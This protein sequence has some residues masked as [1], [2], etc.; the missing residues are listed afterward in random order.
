[1]VTFVEITLL[2]GGRA[3]DGN[4][5]SYDR[6]STGNE[7]GLYDSRSNSDDKSRDGTGRIGIYSATL[8]QNVDGTRE[9]Y[10][11]IG[12]GSMSPSE[13][14]IGVLER[15]Y[16]NLRFRATFNGRAIDSIFPP[17]DDPQFP[18]RGL[19][20]RLDRTAPGRLTRAQVKDLAAWSRIDRVVNPP[21]AVRRQTGVEPV[22]RDSRGNDFSPDVG[23]GDAWGAHSSG[24]SK[25]FDRNGRR[26]GTYDFGFNRIGD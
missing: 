25:A 5:W 8:D 10:W 9:Y 6:D 17:I 13:I 3:A 23:S 16:D 7:V 21:D 26:L 18:S 11:E 14:P 4:G 15:F 19:V 2:Q 20:R 22:Y 12:H 1:M 24:T